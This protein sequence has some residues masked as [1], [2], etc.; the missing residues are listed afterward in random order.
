M[1]QDLTI[2]ELKETINDYKKSLIENELSPR[3]IEKYIRDAKTFIDWIEEEA[4]PISKALTIKY[5]QELKEKYALST[6]NN[7]I[8]TLNKYLKYIGLEDETVKIIRVQ[9]KEIA[10]YISQ[11]DYDRILRQAKS[12]GTSRDVVMLE[13][14]YNTGLRVSELEFLTVEALNQGYI[15]IDN[16]GKVRTVP[17]VTSLKNL[18]KDYI[19]ANNIKTGSIILNRD[20]EPLSRYMIFNRI[21]YLAG[22]A[23]VKKSKAYPHSIRHLFAKN[24]LA[25]NGN[26]VLQ[27]ADILGHES[28]ET[29]RLYTKLD[30]HETRKTMEN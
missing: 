13:I 12:K 20:G 2:A 5:K 7:K 18:L 8:V 24:W 3:T 10:E 6:A 22:Q 27:L 9:S 14:F 28:L 1:K 25:R 29:T 16:K 17:I 23:R 11:T 15:T 30:I 21:K 4:E 26:N 19:K